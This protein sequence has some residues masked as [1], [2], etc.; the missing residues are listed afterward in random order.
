MNDA[1]TNVIDRLND[2]LA[3][4]ALSEVTQDWFSNRGL[5]A[6]VV[7]RESEDYARRQ[8]I[9]IPEWSIAPGAVTTESGKACRIALKA[10][11]HDD[12]QEIR[13][14]TQKAVE[15]ASQVQVQA[16]DP[17][18]LAVGGLILGGLILASRV[19][20][21]GSDGIEFYEGIPKEL[22]DVLKAGSTFFEKFNS[23]F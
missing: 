21:I 16:L 9:V 15:K 6:N 1:S 8:G 13:G 4:R 19:K 3:I 17:V 2:I 20:K 5:Q 10:L 23:L 12:D 22:A 11:F 14:W 7:L 18:S